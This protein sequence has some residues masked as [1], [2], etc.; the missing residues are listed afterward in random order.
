MTATMQR[1][2]KKARLS[3]TVKKINELTQLKRKIRFIQ[4]QIANGNVEEAINNI[5]L[6]PLP[7]SP[8]ERGVYQDWISVEDKPKEVGFFNCK[9]KSDSGG[10]IHSFW[11]DGKDWCFDN[12]MSSGDKLYEAAF[13]VEVTHYQPL[14]P[15]P[16]SHKP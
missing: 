13:Y 4:N 5:V 7:Q 12:W 16:Q 2:L 3:F 11:F 6:M 9:Y 1:K 10:G 15:A 8:T 14:P